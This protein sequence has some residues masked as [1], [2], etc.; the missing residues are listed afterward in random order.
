MIIHIE[1]SI[2]EAKIAHYE[3]PKWHCN[4]IYGKD[5]NV[6]VVWGLPDQKDN[7]LE[8]V[9]NANYMRII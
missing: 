5:V 6:K 7:Q 3:W 2:F 4:N 1:S 9:S 8:C